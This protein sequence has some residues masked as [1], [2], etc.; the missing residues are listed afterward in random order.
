MAIRKQVKVGSG[1]DAL[2]DSATFATKRE[3]N[4]WAAKRRLELQNIKKKRPGHDKTLLDAMRKYSDEESPK[5]KGSRWEQIRL[6]AME[7]HDHMPVTMP[8]SSITAEHFVAWRRAREKVVKPGTVIRDMNLL[9]AMLNTA[10]IEWNWITSNPLSN[11]RRPKSP[12]HRERTITKAEIKTMLRQLGYRWNRRPQS[13]K[14]IVAYAFL[15]E[16]RTMMREGELAGLSW[17][18]FHD[19]WVTLPDTK[20]NDPRHVPVPIK[21]RRLFTRLR[22]L[23]EERPLPITT[24]SID[25]I[26]RKAREQAGLSGF[27]FHDGRHT[28]A[29]WIGRTVGKPGKLSFPEF[30]KVGGWRDPKHALIYVNPT[31][32][33]LADRM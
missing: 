11:V 19:T 33:E 17:E 24:A 14:Q 32:A 21:A 2:R 29:T 4:E 1:P 22:G 16:L 23:D 18:N 20:N 30:C 31:A 12:A 5:R 27:T 8:I 26:F 13:M 7:D 28:A 6:N 9:S 3:A 25:A 10:R 15:I